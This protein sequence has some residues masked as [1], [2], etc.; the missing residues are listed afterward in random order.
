MLNL[1]KKLF[2]IRDKRSESASDNWAA[3]VVVTDEKVA[4]Q[5]VGNAEQVTETKVTPE[6]AACG[7]GR[8]PT[9]KCVGLHNLS[10]AEWAVHKK[11]PA[12]KVAA[13]K[14]VEKTAK[15]PAAKKTAKKN[16]KK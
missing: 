16:V 4:T 3:P 8:S 15:K 6:P 1:L 14:P 7:C 10:D 9:G 5:T 2:G 11:N 12:N 13:S